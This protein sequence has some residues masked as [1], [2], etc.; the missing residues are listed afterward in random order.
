[1]RSPVD[2][3][4]GAWEGGGGVSGR[5]RMEWVLSTMG[6]DAPILPDTIDVARPRRGAPAGDSSY[7]IIS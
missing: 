1:M 3:L 4:Q 5:G 7:V 2:T 6:A